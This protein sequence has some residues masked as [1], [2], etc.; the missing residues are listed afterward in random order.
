[1]R[2]MAQDAGYMALDELKQGRTTMILFPNSLWGAVMFDMGAAPE[3]VFLHVSNKHEALRSVAPHTL[4]LV[5]ANDED[6]DEEGL[7]IAKEKL[8]QAVLPK[9]ISLF[10]YVDGQPV[11]DE[12]REGQKIWE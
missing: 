6:W 3:G 12:V 5:A 1:M 7:E 8:R 10:R 9:L 2:N 4:I 11:D